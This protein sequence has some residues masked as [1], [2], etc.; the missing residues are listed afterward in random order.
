MKL[1]VQQQYLRRRLSRWC[2]GLEVG[3][4][5]PRMCRQGRVE[6][7]RRRE[8]SVLLHGFQ[9]TE[10]SYPELSATYPEGS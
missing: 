2:L 3:W 7:S 5:A 6:G 10:L 4:R 1:P 8:R 9:Q